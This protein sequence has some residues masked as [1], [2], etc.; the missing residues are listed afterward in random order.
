MM[1]SKLVIV[2]AVVLSA[3]FASGQQSPPTITAPAAT[4]FA[5][6]TFCKKEERDKRQL[7]RAA[8]P[9]Q[10]SVLTRTQIE[11]WRDANRTQLSTPQLA[12][13]QELWTTATPQ[14]FEGFFDRTEQ[15]RAK[16]ESWEALAGSAFRGRE[17]DQISPYGPCIAKKDK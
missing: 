11:R 5:Y 16:R 9:E 14:T 3:A 8:T 10:Q 6:E 7:F 12:V 1:A 4:E 13:L 15:A 17:L 2:P